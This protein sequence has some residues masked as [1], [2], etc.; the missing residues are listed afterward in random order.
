MGR[1][2]RLALAAVMAGG[3]WAIRDWWW[4]QREEEGLAGRVALVTGGSRGLG[5]LLARELAREGC[6]VAICARHP[7]Q[8]EEAARLLGAEGLEA[9]TL[10]CDVSDRSQVEDMLG[11]VRAELGPVDVLVNNAASSRWDRL[12]R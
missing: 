2:S 4:P 3:A 8:L 10:T 11:R 5:F 6:R 9:L 12:L 7:E 1:A